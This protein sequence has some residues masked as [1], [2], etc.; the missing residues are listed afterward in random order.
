[1]KKFLFVLF[2]VILFN[3][4]LAQDY[5]TGKKNI[6]ANGVTF[7]VKIGPYSLSLDNMVYERGK[8]PNL[9][10]KD[11]SPVEEVHY[12]ETCEMISGGLAKALMETFS[13]SEY[14]QFQQL[15]GLL[16]WISYI[17]DPDGNTIE[18]GFTVSK[19]AEMLAL[20]PAKF[21]LLENNVKKYVK[22]K[23]SPDGKKVQYMHGL[24]FVNFSRIEL[25]YDSLRKIKNPD[26]L[27]QSD[28]LF[29]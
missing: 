4:S 9:Y 1:M 27:D 3:E 15:E 12:P 8:D 28:A 11:G 6:E 21:A 18:V 24:G 25:P 29:N 10:Y 20:P 19:I 26:F 17:I 23:V 13:E 14:R 7:D 16:F 22:W 5:Y 2:L